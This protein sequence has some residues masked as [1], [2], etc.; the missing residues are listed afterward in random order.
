MKYCIYLIFRMIIRNPSRKKDHSVLFRIL[1]NYY[2]EISLVKDLR[3]DWPIII[4]DFFEKF[5]AVN[6]AHQNLIKVNCF[7]KTCKTYVF[8][9]IIVEGTTPMSKYV[10]GMIIFSVLPF[11]F[12]I[13][14]T[15]IWKILSLTCCR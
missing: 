5:T 2:Q 15:F 13:I 8:F 11:F 10:S 4:I 7:F 6:T 3:L 9:I 12:A 1:T 14:S